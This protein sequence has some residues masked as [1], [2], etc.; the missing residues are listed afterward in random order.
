MT[1]DFTPTDVGIVTP[2]NAADGDL[3]LALDV[4]ANVF[5]GGSA[6]Q[7]NLALEFQ[8]VGGLAQQNFDTN[9]IQGLISGGLVDQISN[10]SAI[11]NNYLDLDGNGTSD[12]YANAN[13]QID[14]NTVQVSEPSTLALAGL[15]LLAVGGLRR[16]RFNK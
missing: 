16:H 15:A 7:G 4:I 11:F 14:G 8:A 10:N 12:Y 13:G 9:T 5:T 3:W 1:R 6:V 2:G